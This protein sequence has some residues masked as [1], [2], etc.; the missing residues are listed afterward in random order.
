M[1]FP[2]LKKL[3]KNVFEDLNDFLYIVGI[4]SVRIL[5]RVRRR[6][7][8]F[9]R[10]AT[11]LFKHLYAV[12]VG[13]QIAG[14]KK[15]IRSIREGFSIAGKRISEAKKQGY[16]RTFTEYVWVAGKSFVRHRGFLFSILNILVPVGATFLL[17]MTVQHWTGLT[18]GLVLSYDGQEVATIQN[19]KVFEQATELVSQRMVHDTV[20]SDLGVKFT[21]TF[22]LAIV[23]ASRFSTANYVCD[24]IIQQSNGIIEEA[25]GLYVDGDLIGTVKSSADLR[26]ILQNILNKA[27]GSDTGAT[28][29]FAEDVETVTGL[30]PTTTIITTEAMNKL[31]TGTSKSGVTYTVKDGDTATSI[32]KANNT[33]IAELNKINNNQIGDDLH[34]GDLI[35]LEVSVPMLGVE[36]VKN[37]TYQ[38]PLSY[39]TVTMQDDSQYTDYSKV[40]T[41]GANGVQQCVDKVYYVNGVESK[42]D[43]ITRTVITPS[44]DKVVI[45]G[46]KKRPKYSSSGESTGSLMWPVP[47]LHTITTY[48]TW[49]WGSF[50]TG[51][52]IS[53]GGAY[54]RTIVAA[55]GGVVVSSGWK[56]GYGNCVQINHGGGIQ[57]LYG[58]ASKLLVRAGQRVSKGQA[59][60][61]VGSTG[62]STGPHCHF[63]VIKNGT[64]VNPLG[65]VA[66]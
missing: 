27:R 39:K 9:L 45:T 43:V 59:I 31:I 14:L 10:P 42:R 13:R 46:T 36:L 54:G 51:I 61:L 4:Q 41:E 49:R 62:N 44:V 21:P 26:F 18:Y 15:E 8:R 7:T 56:N 3:S 57:T 28:A 66:R 30:F 55:D 33:T 35:N 40:K 23:D 53:G 58:H 52:D 1:Q 48:F 37:I 29:A 11:N 22:Q 19:E 63:E 6:L 65:Y 47:S 34:P 60:A 2:K 17:V 16:W 5:K 12:S 20:A 64:K 25:S 32:A 38:V 24:Q 50:H